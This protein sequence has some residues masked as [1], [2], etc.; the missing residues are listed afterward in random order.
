MSSVLNK[1]TKNWG[2]ANL[3]DRNQDTCWN[4]E[5]GKSQWLDITFDTPVTIKEINIL[6]QGGFVGRVCLLQSHE[7]QFKDI[8]RFYPDDINTRQVFKVEGEGIRFRL[9]FETSSDFFGRIVIYDI[10]V[11]GSVM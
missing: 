9:S 11:L 6:F 10:D 4:S 5:Q 7:E 8:T 1:D 3:I 2:K